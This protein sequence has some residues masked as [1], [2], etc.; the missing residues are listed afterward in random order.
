MQ[1]NKL[2]LF[3]LRREQIPIAIFGL[4]L[5]AVVGHLVVLRF[6]AV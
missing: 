1:S 3:R 6:F 4:I 2:S 5:G